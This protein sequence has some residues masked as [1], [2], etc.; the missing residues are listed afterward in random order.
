MKK[1]ENTPKNSSAIPP[2]WITPGLIAAA[3]FAAFMTATAWFAAG[4]RHVHHHDMIADLTFNLGGREVREHCTACH[5]EGGPA[6]VHGD[7]QA[8]TPH[9]D[10]DPHS[11]EVLGC[12]SCHLG[13]GMA[14][15]IKLS[16]GQGGLGA[17]QVLSG[18]E[19]Q[20]RC[21]ACHVLAP[22]DGAERPWQGYHLFRQRACSLCHYLDGLGT[23]GHFGPELSRVGSQLGLEQLVTAIRDP[24]SEPP[25]S[26]MPRF[27]LSRGQARDLSLFLK[28]RVAD[29]LYATPMQI[30]A[31]KV[32]L[33]DIPLLPEDVELL[34]GEDLLYRGKCLACHKFGEEDGYIAP[35][36]THIGLM[37]SAEFIREFLERPNR[38]IPGAIMPPSPLDTLERDALTSFLVHESTA[39]DAAAHDTAAHEVAVNEHSQVR[40]LY[41]HQCQRCHAADGSGRCPIEPNLATFPRALTDNGEFFRQIEDQRLQRSIERGIAGTSMPPYGDLIEEA[42]REELLDLLFTAF[43]G[44]DRHEKVALPPLPPLPQHLS[45]PEQT[46]G[47]YAKNCHICHGRTGT[48]KGPEYLQYLPRPRN[49]T[50]TPY[51]SALSD[52]HIA[53]AIAHGVPGTAMPG[54]RDHLQAQ[55]IWDLVARVRALSGEHP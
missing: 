16:H 25:N 1:I 7:S 54:F 39:H 40:Q 11:V 52:E 9:P 2:R 15:D 43:I 27:P 47:V 38:L 13:E 42:A 51:F 55:Q 37:R 48:G 20:G 29:P 4:P 24:R 5:V 30:Q 21:Y 53:R 36:L 35:D 49:L 32:K 41:M 18:T 6:T 17:R 45:D 19:V 23:G 3:L 28:S 12:T 44:I 50:N 46:D 34:P 14:M 26:I 22:L 33:P 8:G 31:G 10:I